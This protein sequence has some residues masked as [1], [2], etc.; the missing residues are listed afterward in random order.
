[1]GPRISRST[2]VTYHSDTD[3]STYVMVSNV[4]ESRLKFN[5]ETS[6]MLAIG[7][8]KQLGIDPALLSSLGD[9]VSSDAI[10]IREKFVSVFNIKNSDVYCSSESPDHCTCTGIQRA[11]ENGVKGVRNDG[12]FILFMSGH[13]ISE[14]F[15]FAPADFNPSDE[16]TYLTADLV[17][18]AIIRAGCKAKYVIILLDCCYSGAMASKITGKLDDTSKTSLLSNVYVLAA[19]TGTQ[20][21]LA[22]PYLKQS[23]FTYFLI[24]ALRLHKNPLMPD[25]IP[26]QK[27]FEEVKVCSGAL[28][29]LPVYAE[30]RDGKLSGIFKRPAVPSLASF[31]PTSKRICFDAS[32]EQPGQANPCSIV[33]DLLDTT[34]SHCRLDNHSLDWINELPNGLELHALCEK[35]LLSGN[36]DV[37]TVVVLLIMRSIAIHELVYNPTTVGKRNVVLMA[38]MSIIGALNAVSDHILPI[39]RSHLY[40]SCIFWKAVLKKYKRDD[41][42]TLLNDLLEDIKK[43]MQKA[44]DE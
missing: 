2:D 8:D 3:D 43:A 28:S 40:L 38:F 5:P 10:H 29:S 41:E 33:T 31:M 19:A 11:I 44:G 1:M 13:G 18:G 21:S 23:F 32:D 30:E 12:I 25:V 34:G 36:P 35:G 9:T 7:V 6:Y 22:F 24:H 26:I 42:S 17:R 39:D 20:I 37:L 16:N 14:D 27:I 4:P 15:A